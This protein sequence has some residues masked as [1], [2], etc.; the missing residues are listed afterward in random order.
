MVRML[1]E[2]KLG[3]VLVMNSDMDSDFLSIVTE[4]VLLALMK[5]KNIPYSADYYDK[6][7]VDKVKN[8]NQALAQSMVGD[9][10]TSYGLINIAQ[11]GKKMKVKLITM[12]KKL[13]GK[14]MT[15]STLQLR[16]MLLGIV[17]LSK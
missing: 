4:Q 11:K 14:L 17:H 8:F 15:D 2:L 7:K 16:Y 6:F 10:A 5:A 12:G 9:Y 13:Q 1:P 3:L